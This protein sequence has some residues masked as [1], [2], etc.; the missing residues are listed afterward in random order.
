MFKVHD[1]NKIYLR[2]DG[3]ENVQVNQSSLFYIMANEAHAS[4]FDVA[5]RGRFIYVYIIQLFS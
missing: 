3:I 4:D 5:I 1:P 2:G